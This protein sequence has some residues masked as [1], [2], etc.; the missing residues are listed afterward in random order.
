MS[1]RKALVWR[2]E[3]ISPKQRPFR[4]PE[5]TRTQLWSRWKANIEELVANH[6]LT[7]GRFVLGFKLRFTGW[8][9]HIFSQHTRP[10]EGLG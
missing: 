7:L 5:T 9:H 8:Y 2:A 3:L 1:G 4:G 6:N 10:Y